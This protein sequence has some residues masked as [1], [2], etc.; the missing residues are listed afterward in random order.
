MT[1][2]ITVNIS[3]LTDRVDTLQTAVTTLQ[4]ELVQIRNTIPVN[5]PEFTSP[6]P[7]NIQNA[8]PPVDI[9][10]I[11]TLLTEIK[12]IL[13]AN[14]SPSPMPQVTPLLETYPLLGSTITVANWNVTT[15][16]DLSAIVDGNLDTATGW[17][18]L[19]GMWNKGHFEVDLGVEG[20][21]YIEV[22]IGLQ[23]DPGWPNALLEYSIESSS[24]GLGFVPLWQVRLRPGT[25][26][27]TRS[28]CVWM[29]G[30]YVRVC[31]TD[32][33]D[34]QPRLRVYSFKVWKVNVPTG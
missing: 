28:I 2:Q 26:E 1:N 9:T 3:A 15:P 18:Q 24:F 22:K 23:V 5:L 8:S 16:T 25:T 33:G 10:G 19:T 32:L 30:R 17:G 13:Q 31:A 34:G 4:T 27:V 29:S 21:Y 20:R 12:S 6:V 14:S 11:S 7:V